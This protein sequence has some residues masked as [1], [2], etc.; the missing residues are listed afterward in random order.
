MNCTKWFKILY[1]TVNNF[2]EKKK[3]RYQNYQ[4]K[5][6]DEHLENNFQMFFGWMKW[7][8]KILA[9]TQR[10]NYGEETDVLM[11][12][13]T[14]STVK[15]RGGS[16]LVW[17][18]ILFQWFW[19]GHYMWLKEPRMEWCISVFWKL[20]W[21]FQSKN[22]TLKIFGSF[23]HGNDP[24]WS[25]SYWY[26]KWNWHTKFKFQP[27]LLSSNTF[28]KGMNSSILSLAMG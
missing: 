14:I 17:K 4:M 5:S 18:V 16:I 12:N 24:N 8:L 28:E 7:K 22:S 13:K 15:C 27:V 6:V 2:L 9:I 11:V 3:K 10:I 25:A 26:R 23:Q 1:L 19:G 21:S 20:T